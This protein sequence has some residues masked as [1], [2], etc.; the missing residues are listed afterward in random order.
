MHG[1]FYSSFHFYPGDGIVAISD[2]PP[3]IVSGTAAAVVSHQMETLYAVELSTGELYRWF[4][5]FELQGVQPK[6]N[7]DFQ[8]GDFAFT[9]TDKGHPPL[10]K[11]GM[12]VRIIKVLPH[13]HFY[14]LLLEDGKYRRW[15]ADFEVTF[16]I[17]HTSYSV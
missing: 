5:G 10:I 16:P 8:L 12:P 1:T 9:V 13:T 7:G 6:Q 3:D 15:L 14:D 2:L 4:A 11:I 17:R